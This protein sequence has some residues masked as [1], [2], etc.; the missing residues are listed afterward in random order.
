[1]FGASPSTSRG[2][3]AR[4]CLV[5]IAGF[6]ARPVVPLVLAVVAWIGRAARTV[7]KTKQSRL[8]SCSRIGAELVSALFGLAPRRP[9]FRFRHGYRASHSGLRL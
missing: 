5:Q 8:A 2:Q 9:L 6:D 1:M 3:N 4:A 7:A